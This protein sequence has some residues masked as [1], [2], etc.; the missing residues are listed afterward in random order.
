MAGSTSVTRMLDRHKNDFNE[1]DASKLLQKLESNGVIT[2]DEKAQLDE[3]ATPSSRTEGLITIVSRKGYSA[4]QDLCLSLESV[5]PHLLTKFALDIAGSELEGSSSTNNLKL[6]LQ[7]ALK[8]R[9]SVLRENAAAVQQRESALRQYSEMKNER[10]RA[11]ANLESLSP[12]LSNRVSENNHHHPMENGDA[13]VVS[14]PSKWNDK[15]CFSEALVDPVEESGAE[16][17]CWEFHNVVLT[18][19]QGYGFGIAV[20]GGKDNPNFAN[21]DPSI[22]I[23]DVLKAGPAEGK[24]RINDRVISANGVSLENV[25]YATAVQI[26]RECGPT[27]NLVIKR[28]VV[29]PA[30]NNGPQTLKV[31][32]TKNKKK[33][34]FGIVLGCWIYIKEITNKSLLTKE[35]SVHEGDIITK[36]NSNSVDGLTFKEAKKLIDNSKEKLHLVV[37][38]DGSKTTE[39]QEHWSNSN[40][41]I[42]DNNIS[43]NKDMPISPSVIDISSSRSLWSNQNVY[44]QSPTRDFKSST[45]KLTDKNNLAR[46]QGN[47]NHNL[48]ENIHSP[49]D[50][51]NQMPMNAHSPNRMEDLY[52]PPRPPLPQD[53]RNDNYDYFRRSSTPPDPRFISF[54]KDG[55]VGIRL[56]GGNDVGIFVTGVQHGTPAFLQGLQSGDKILK[57]NDIDMRGFTKEEAV[58][59]LVGIQDQV[60]LI[61]QYRKEEYED[62]INN[63]KGDSFYIRTH[64]SHESTGKGELS[65]RKGEVFHIVDTLHNGKPGSWLVY[66]L[67]R[68]GQ[69]IQRGVIPN[70][71]RAKELAQSQNVSSKKENEESGRGSFFRR[72]AR[73]SKSLCKDHWE[74]IVLADSV[75]RF[76]PY[77]RVVLKQPGFI[78]PV[79]LFGPITDVVKERLLKDY[80]GCYAS[81]QSDNQLEDEQSNLKSPG[82]IRLSAIRDVIDKGKHAIL[83]ITPSA[84]DRLNYA[85]FYPVVVFMHAENKHIIKELRN[86]WA[87]SSYKSSRKLYEHACKLEKLW[88]HIFTASISLSTGDSW[89]KKLQETIDRQQKQPLWVSEAKPDEAITDDF[90]F[91]MTSRLSYASSPES[92]LD[93]SMEARTS[94]F[95]E[96]NEQ[97]DRRLVKSSSD[98]SITAA[99]ELADAKSYNRYPSYTLGRSSHHHQETAIPLQSVFKNANDMLTV[100]AKVLPVEQEEYMQH[101]S[102]SN[103]NNGTY[104]VQQ[105]RTRIDPY[106]TLTPSERVANQISNELKNMYETG[107]RSLNPRPPQIDRTSKPSVNYDPNSY[108]SNLPDVN[109]NVP[110]DYINTMEN[111]D[112][113]PP[114]QDRTIFSNGPSYPDESPAVPNSPPYTSSQFSVRD[115]ESISPRIQPNPSIPYQSMTLDR[116]KFSQMKNRH[117]IKPP[118]P[119]PPVKSTKTRLS[120][121]RPVPPPKPSLLQSKHWTA[122]SSRPPEIPLKPNLPQENG[123]TPLSPYHSRSY[124]TSPSKPPPPPK[125]KDPSFYKQFQDNL[126]DIPPDAAM[127]H[128]YSQENMCTYPNRPYSNVM[129]NQKNGPQISPSP[130]LNLDLSARENRGSAFELYKKSDG[131]HQDQNG[132]RKKYEDTE[133]G[134]SVIASA[135]G[136][137]GYEGGTLTSRETGVTILIPPGA[138]SEGE[139][140]EIYFK[141]CQDPNMLPPLDKDKGE[142]L[143]SPLVM[144]GPHGLKFNIPIELRLPHCASISPDSWSFALKSSDTANGEPAEWQNLES[145]DGMTSSRVENDYVSVLVDHF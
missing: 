41:Y 114:V 60:N 29:L 1:L 40:R 21:G 15:P 20:S 50:N 116:V 110:H 9:D 119:P 57:V 66:R 134:H 90:L 145:R 4:F 88:S 14:S 10:D 118:P 143:L 93:I 139:R 34:D 135:Q 27:V 61:V 99:E 102:K 45:T 101:L 59:L 13:E 92:D 70:N 95:R 72:R 26:L 42:A 108:P 133:D 48:T 144:C 132:L 84:V 96:P 47:W 30:N 32:L 55:T 87:K 100:P 128:S 25:D 73:R 126:A 19:L 127:A 56:T 35:E 98:P 78:R 85:Q 52:V 8:E 104:G 64:F 89:Y 142:T 115:F 131:L 141:V 103:S 39:S 83:D 138:I 113:L 44:V 53:N 49:P 2:K 17:E 6:G 125:R 68:N 11:I 124:P 65:F 75:T 94:S 69:E 62:V 51:L 76:P 123:H 37:R 86:K 121:G 71:S 46:P 12:K 79:V 80:P 129:F 7:L 120:D 63:Q 54:Q 74:D 5:C 82:I 58:A 28:R 112:I 36:I 38:R 43:P 31:T 23:S 3:A 33:E 122:D 67:G 105:Q 22:A 111:F 136:V 18:R 130:P 77:E 137:F 107:P 106:A 109:M 91:P 97:K 81:P 117:D 140:H 24:L 16:R